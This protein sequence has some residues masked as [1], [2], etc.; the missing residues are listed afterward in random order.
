MEIFVFEFFTGG[1]LWLRPAGST[2]SPIANLPL[3]SLFRE[4]AAMHQALLDDFGRLPRAHVTTLHDVRVESPQACVT[5][6]SV[7]DEESFWIELERACR[8]ADY[9]LLVAPECHGWLLSLVRTAERLDARLLGPGSE[10][11]QWASDKHATADVLNRHQA[12]CTQG[13]RC[14]QI[15]ESD[16]ARDWEYPVVAKPFD[17]AGSAGIYRVHDRHQLQA[18]VQSGEIRV[19]DRCEPLYPGQPGSVAI[20]CGPGAACDLRPCWQH[21]AVD[22]TFRYSGGQIM[23]QDEMA[24]RA[25]RLIAPLQSLWQTTVGLIGVDF[26]LGDDPNGRQDVIIEVNPR[27]TTSYIG[28]QRYYCGNLAQAMIDVAEGCAVDIDRQG[29][30]PCSGWDWTSVEPTSKSPTVGSSR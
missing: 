23:R 17:G 4:V 14:R 21:I 15:W 2:D 13:M 1:G 29:Y 12:I 3:A 5:S 11:V 7:S 26:I 18:L 20:L 30:R 22:G 24:V 16:A 19:D 27:V 9:V 8:R 6:A 10:F 25:Q 28:L